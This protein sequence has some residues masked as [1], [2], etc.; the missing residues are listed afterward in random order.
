MLLVHVMLT[1]AELKPVAAR[2][3]ERQEASHHHTHLSFRN[4]DDGVLVVGHTF[5]LDVRPSFIQ[6]PK[7]FSRTPT[8]SAFA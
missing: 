3:N 7:V 8:Q 5:F 1:D 2:R 6:Q 4:D